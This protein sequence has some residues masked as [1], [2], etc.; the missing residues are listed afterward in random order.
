MERSTPADQCKFLD[1]A[2]ASCG[3]FRTQAIVGKKANFILQS[4]AEKWIEESKQ[5]S[6]MIQGLEKAVG[7]K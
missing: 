6:A 3:E 5:L 7:S 4:V 2:G 1:Y